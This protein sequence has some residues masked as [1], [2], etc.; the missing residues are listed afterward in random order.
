M[1]VGRDTH[2]LLGPM[3]GSTHD[4]PPVTDAT[5]RPAAA[6][7][8]PA[9]PGRTKLEIC[10]PDD[11]WWA[12]VLASDQADWK[13]ALEAQLSP[14]TPD[15]I[16]ARTERM[17]EDRVSSVWFSGRMRAPWFGAVPWLA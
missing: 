8:P 5:T 12:D 16:A 17:L 7:P 6:R 13:T 4:P 14:T 9:T 3:G 10:G 11:A 1:R 2:S 15:D